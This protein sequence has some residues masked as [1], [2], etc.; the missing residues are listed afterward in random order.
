MM[1]MM[2][3][4]MA[5]SLISYFSMF[6]ALGRVIHFEAC[7]QWALLS[8]QI[9]GLV[10]LPYQEAETA[11]RSMR[12]NSC[13]KQK[14]LTPEALTR[15]GPARPDQLDGASNR[16]K[17]CCTSTVGPAVPAL[18]GRTRWAECHS[19][20]ATTFVFYSSY[21]VYLSLLAVVIAVSQFWGPVI[22]DLL[23]ECYVLLDMEPS[24]QQKTILELESTSKWALLHDVCESDTHREALTTRPA[25]WTHHK[26]SERPSCTFFRPEVKKASDWLELE[27]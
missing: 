10:T 3:S 1:M 12:T 14:P 25:E 19:P 4:Y 5:Q 27:V 6:G 26:A 24:I 20:Q 15:N 17:K 22:V 23:M 16:N 11:S 21:S 9:T 2:Q 18:L 7:C 13:Q 8:V